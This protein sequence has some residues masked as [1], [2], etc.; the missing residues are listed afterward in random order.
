MCGL[1]GIS[2]AYDKLACK[3]DYGVQMGYEK[4]I[5]GYNRI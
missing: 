5:Y 4:D 3:G 2:P 1:L